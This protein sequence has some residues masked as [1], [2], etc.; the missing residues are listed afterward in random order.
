MKGGNIVRLRGGHISI[1]LVAL[2]FMSILLWAWDKSYFA[3]LL[4][5]TREKFMMPVS[6][7]YSN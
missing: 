4:P 1:A 2:M 3:S 5:L 7:N 6:G